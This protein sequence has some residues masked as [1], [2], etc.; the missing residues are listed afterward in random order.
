MFSGWST[1]DDGN[2]IFEAMHQMDQ[3]HLQIGDTGVYT[4]AV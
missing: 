2:D 3:I 1:A 4:P